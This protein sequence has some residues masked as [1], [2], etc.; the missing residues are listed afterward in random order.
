MEQTTVRRPKASRIPRALG[1][2]LWAPLAVVF[3]VGIPLNAVGGPDWLIFVALI[4]AVVVYLYCVHRRLSKESVTWDSDTIEIHNAW[5]SYSIP[6]SDVSGIDM[7]KPWWLGLDQGKSDLSVPV[8]K[9]RSGQQVPVAVMYCE[10]SKPDGETSKKG[11]RAWVEKSEIQSLLAD[12]ESHG[13][14]APVEGG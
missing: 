5:K 10:G 1:L 11:R 4:A 14:D 13:A 2:S 9:T 12:A 3:A 6:W 7:E 8:V